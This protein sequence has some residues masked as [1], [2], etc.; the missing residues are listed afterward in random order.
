MEYRVHVGFVPRRPRG[1]M[2]LGV[3]WGGG[4][5]RDNYKRCSCIEE[6]ETSW[7]LSRSFKNNVARHARNVCG[8]GV[9]RDNYKRSSSLEECETLWLLSRTM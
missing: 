2:G 6:C 5:G 9:G 8:G 4:V 1:L 3:G 7:L